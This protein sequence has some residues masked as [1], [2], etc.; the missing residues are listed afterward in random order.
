MPRVF[1]DYLPS[2]P[3]RYG[4]KRFLRLVCAER[5]HFIDIFRETQEAGKPS[6]YSLP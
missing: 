4:S 1:R 2:W 6:P 5:L 3:I